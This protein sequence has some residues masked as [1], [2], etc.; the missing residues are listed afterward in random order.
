MRMLLVISLALTNVKDQSEGPA[1]NGLGRLP[2]TKQ[3]IIM[4]I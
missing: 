3:M 4:L 1:Q 2:C